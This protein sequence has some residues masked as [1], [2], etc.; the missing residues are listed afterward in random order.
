[1]GLSS[2]IKTKV[3]F[4]SHYY[5]LSWILVI[6]RIESSS[7][8]TKKAVSIFLLL[9]SWLVFIKKKTS[10]LEHYH[11][12]LLQ[13]RARN[14]FGDSRGVAVWIAAVDMVRA[15]APCLFY[16]EVI[17]LVQQRARSRIPRKIIHPL[18]LQRYHRNTLQLGVAIRSLHWRRVMGLMEMVVVF[19]SIQ[20]WMFIRVIFLA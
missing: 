13:S 8:C 5:Q 14:R 2:I 3:E 18:Q 15:Y 20:C 6:I 12:L 11:V 17:Q 10:W 16:R 9:T 7:I 19:E 4:L 1:M